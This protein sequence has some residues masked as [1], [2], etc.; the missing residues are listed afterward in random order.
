MAAAAVLLKLL[1]VAQSERIKA[2]VAIHLL[3]VNG[4]K[5]PSS[6][7]PVVNVGLSVGYVV[8]LSGRREDPPT[9]T[10]GEAA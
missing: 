4:H 9:V 3:A 7:A 10:P 8:D 6:G 1:D 5:P 2:D